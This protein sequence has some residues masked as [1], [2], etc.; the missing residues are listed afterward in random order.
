MVSLVNC[1]SPLVW[2]E[3]MLGALKVYARA[4]QAVIVAPFALAGANTPAS[5]VGAVA[6]INAEALAGVAFAQL[7]RPGSPM[8]YGHFLAAVSMKTGAPMAGTP[9]LAFM[10][11]MIG[12]L[13]RKYRLP[14]RSS[15]MLAGSKRVDAQAGYEAIQNMYGAFLSGANF[16]LHSAGWNEAGLGA[17]FA[18]FVLDCEQVAMFYRLGQGPQFGDLEAALAAVREIGP[19]GHYLGTE[20]T[21][22]HFQTAFF[23][24]EL[25][26]NNSFEQW[27]LDGAKDANARALEAAQRMLESYQAPPLDPAVDEALLAFIREREAVLPDSLE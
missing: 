21:Q 17:S 16:I 9:E 22:D 13:A 12:Q 8:I 18:K 19:G 11:F 3:T 23:M 15:G 10:N 25:L 6:Q 24:P 5:A 1:N 14:L 4:N 2:D 26:D 7:C 27:E 20:H